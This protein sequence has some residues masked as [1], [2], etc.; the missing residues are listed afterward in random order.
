M[1]AVVT[2]D[3]DL[4]VL[5]PLPHVAAGRREPQELR[6]RHKIGRHGRDPAMD[7]AEAQEL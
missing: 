3:L 7:G 6:L 5:S 1:H 4:P 2:Q